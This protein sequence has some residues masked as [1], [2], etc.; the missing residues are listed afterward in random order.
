ML[1]VGTAE[2]L[3]NG[4]EINVGITYQILSIDPQML[5]VFSATVVLSI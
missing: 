1:A 4:D 5:V 2:D 3:L